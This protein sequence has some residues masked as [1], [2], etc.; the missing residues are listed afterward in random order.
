MSSA[1]ALVKL[2]FLVKRLLAGTGL[3]VPYYRLRSAYRHASRDRYYAKLVQVYANPLSIVR[4][5]FDKLGSS[6]R[7]AEVSEVARLFDGDRRAF[8]GTILSLIGF[9]GQAV[10]LR[11]ALSTCGRRNL[12]RA[13]SVMACGVEETTLDSLEHDLRGALGEIAFGPMTTVPAAGSMREALHAILERIVD[14]K[15]CPRFFEIDHID[16]IEEILESRYSIGDLASV[17]RGHLFLRA[18][19]ALLGCE[20]PQEHDRLPS[21]LKSELVDITRYVPARGVP[22]PFVSEVIPDLFAEFCSIRGADNP[23]RFLQIN[24]EYSARQH[25][26][27][28]EWDSRDLSLL[29]EYEHDHHALLRNVIDLIRVGRISAAD[30]VL[31]LGPRHVDELHFFRKHLGLYRTIGLDLFASDKGR[32]LAGDMHDMPFE[33]GRFKLVYVCNTLTYAYNARKVIREIC[34]VTQS[35]GYAMLIDSGNRVNGPDPLG[36]SDLM[37]ADVV[38]RCFHMRPYKTIVKDKGKSLAPEWYLEQPCVLLEL[39]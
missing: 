38:V 16:D 4:E 28:G 25:D 39:D 17:E 21:R 34:R 15:R 10:Q 12:L 2:K 29:R 31:I 8:L 13:M 5:P 23:E 30:E 20:A 9:K 37:S 27:L 32:I 22:H 3:L 6:V 11:S 19:R 24:R 33:S 18:L 36:R 35:P 14:V 1:A 7:D 26:S